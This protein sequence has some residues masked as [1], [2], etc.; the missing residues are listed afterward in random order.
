MQLRTIAI[1]VIAVILV[2]HF[3][4]EHIHPRILVTQNEHRYY[5]LAIRAPMAGLPPH[6]RSQYANL[7]SASRRISSVDFPL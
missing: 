2:A 3:Y 6:S 5:E 4:V 7:S 1:C